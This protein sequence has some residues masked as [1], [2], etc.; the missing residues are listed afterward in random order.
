MPSFLE[1]QEAA[2]KAGVLQG[3][4][5]L[6]TG[7]YNMQVVSVKS[8]HTKKNDP[9]L[10]VLLKT[11]DGRTTFMNLNYIADN[12][13]GNA[14]T[15]QMLQDLGITR[16]FMS[17]VDTSQGL[18]PFVPEL[19]R[20]STGR[21]YAMHVTTKSG[22]GEWAGKL[23]SNFKMRSNGQAAAAQ[24]QGSP[25]VQPAPAPAVRPVAVPV[26][27]VAASSPLA[28][29]VPGNEGPPERSPIPQPAPTPLPAQ[30]EPTTG[31]PPR[32]GI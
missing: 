13:V 1:V 12:Q 15:I 14:L 17:R 5:K 27:V 19:V 21:W 18:E 26:T 2:E 22:T 8:G 31:L 25:V 29:A 30:A 23:N 28:M 16:E 9:S 6:P 11:E 20:V 24:F 3:A 32:P 10:S 7:D 4:D